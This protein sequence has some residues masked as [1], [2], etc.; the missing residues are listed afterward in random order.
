M[1]HEGLHGGKGTRRCSSLSAEILC[2]SGASSCPHKGH[3]HC[4]FEPNYQ[5]QDEQERLR[6]IETSSAGGP[7]PWGHEKGEDELSQPHVCPAGGWT[8]PLR[9]KKI[10]P[11]CFQS[12][13]TLQLRGDHFCVQFTLF[14]LH[15]KFGEKKL[16]ASL[17]TPKLRV[18]EQYQG[19]ST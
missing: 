17:Y 11:C 15:H 9:S 3:W 14:C 5:N 1:V 8:W 6:F 13:C 16:V 10:Q 12:P 18:K 19:N 4:T 7:R 2:R